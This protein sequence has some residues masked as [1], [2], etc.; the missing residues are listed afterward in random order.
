MI[1]AAGLVHRYPGRPNSLEGVDLLL[2][3]VGRVALLGTSGSGKSTLALCLAALLDPV[4]GTVE[5]DGLAAAGD[6]RVVAWRVGLL[7]QY[8]Q[9]QILTR[10]VADEVALPLENLGWARPDI[11]TRVAEVLDGLGLARL[12][13]RD[14]HQL[15]GGEMQRAALAAAL[16]PRPRYLFLDEPLAHLDRAA[17]MDVE[18]WLLRTGIGDT[19]LRLDIAPLPAPGDG[20]HR[21]LVLERGRLIH[22]GADL[23]DPVRERLLGIDPAP[24]QDTALDW[25]PQPACCGMRTAGLAIGHGGRVLAEEIDLEL[26]PGTITAL[27]GP[28]GCGKSTLLLTLAGLLDPLRGRVEIDASP[29]RTVTYLPQFAE[30]L[31]WR[32][33]VAEELDSFGGDQAVSGATPESG[34]EPAELLAVGLPAGTAHT[35]PFR[36]SGGER[37]RL[38][39]ACALRARRP[40]L[41]LDEPAAGLDG[42]GRGILRRL[43]A[44]VSG[45]G[46]TVLFVAHERE[47]L[48]WAGRVLEIRDGRLVDHGRPDERA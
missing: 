12:A 17:A 48:G 22:D 34:Q 36:L 24:E 41:L 5:I 14:P 9:S 10:S 25:S 7:F 43:L 39:L 47:L 4:A 28:S 18:H 3:E 21:R 19:S 38:A 20:D 16:A 1:R 26:A 13:D 6:R 33:T 8:P 30:Q 37:R 11:R 35:S 15:S 46:G 32:P 40:V 29:R 45:A 27:T 44:R 42:P 2:P 31:F 23:P